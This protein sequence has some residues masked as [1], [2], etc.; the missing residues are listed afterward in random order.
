MLGAQRRM[1]VNRWP[2]LEVAYEYF[3][4]EEMQNAHNAEYDTLNCYKVYMQL[5][6]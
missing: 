6:N 1:G 5:V 4:N 2:K 3:F